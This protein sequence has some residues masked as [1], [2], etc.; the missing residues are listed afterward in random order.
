MNLQHH[1]ALSF[2]STLFTIFIL[3]LNPLPQI[4]S[5]SCIIEFNPTNIESAKTCN[6]S[7]NTWGGFIDGRNCCRSSFDDYLFGLAKWASQ[8]GRI[9]LNSSDQSI[10]LSSDEKNLGSCGFDR[11]TSGGGANG[12]C[13]SYTVADVASKLDSQLESM[14]ENCNLTAGGGGGGG[15]G[16]GRC[17][18]KWREI[19]ESLNHGSKLEA[20]VC[21]FA[22][23]VTLMSNWVGISREKVQ[24][25]FDCISHD[26]SSI[27]GGSSGSGGR[28]NSKMIKSILIASIGIGGFVAIIVVLLWIIISRRKAKEARTSAKSGSFSKASQELK[29]KQPNKLKI[30]I[31]EIYSATNHLDESNYIGQGIAGKVYKGIMSDGQAVAVKHIV[32][33]GHVETFVREV[34]SLSHVR[35]PNLVA[36][37][38]CCK[39]EDEYFLVYELCKN[40]N[41]SEWLYSK[42]KNLSWIQRIETAIDCARGLWFLHTYPSGSIVHRD[43]KASIFCLF[44]FAP[45]N[46][47]LDTNFQAKLSDFG[48]SKVM[49]LGQSFV[50]S[51]VRGTFGYVDP[52]YQRNHHVNA[53]G[54]VYSF[55]IVLMQL[56]SGQKVINMNHN[57]HMQLNKKAS[58]LAANGKVAEFAD[59][60]LNGEYSLEAFE[61]IFKLAVTCSGRKQDRPTMEMVVTRLEKALQ[62]SMRLL[63]DR[64]MNISTIYDRSINI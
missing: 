37:I 43:I 47:L 7:E 32:N 2:F 52:E 51:E 33:D 48:L 34:T 12:E 20:D 3:L 29:F 63:N 57:R 24:Q 8:S 26:S 36:L 64:S 62:I 4:Y 10:C 18:E 38:G 56:L 5:Q 19:G 39:H 17:R 53:K 23:L 45:T 27:N 28:K 30:S 21:R 49:N 58:F 46:I 44:N 35:H 15:S 42:E 40:G 60:K 31:K 50:S 54:D 6:D 55:G 25:V 1:Q 59:P 11:L 16:C 9:F 22:V 13:S 14:F 61:I 41:L